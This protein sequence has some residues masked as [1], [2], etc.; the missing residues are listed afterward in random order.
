[1]KKISSIIILLAVLFAVTNINAQPQ[2][3]IHVFGGYN[4]PLGGLGGNSNFPSTDATT[5]Y[6][7]M[8]S[9]FNAGADFKYFLGK[10]RAFGL[11]INVAYNGY[12]TGDLTA[13]GVGYG[14]MKLN[15]VRIGIGAE[16]DFL[17]KGKANPFIGI[18]LTGNFLS[19][20]FTADA[21]APEGV[22]SGTMNS[23]S[24]FGLAI[25]AGLDIKVGKVWG[26]VIGLKYDM[27]N[28]IGKQDTS[29][30]TNT[31]TTYYLYDKS[32]TN[33]AG[34]SVNALNMSD[35]Q[36]YGGVSFFFGQPKTMVKK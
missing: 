36:F 20:K 8:K 22:L 12:S 1:M 35:I 25:G 21:T 34:T 29:A 2:M 15:D 18:D 23:A 28:L 13:S 24:R 6:L 10:K 16:Y 11:L 9:G 31:S 7:Y 4:V 27:M 14:T 26:F 33:A 5:P 30:G 17:P 19:G 3:K 32:Y